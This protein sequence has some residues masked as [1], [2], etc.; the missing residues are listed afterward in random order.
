M[1]K[2]VKASD[3]DNF[4]HGKA[5]VGGTPSPVTFTKNPGMQS[6]G[7]NTDIAK[8]QPN[9]LVTNK[10]ATKKLVV[11]ETPYASENVALLQRHIVYAK[12]CLSDSLKRGEAP[13]V[14]SLLYPQVLDDRVKLDHDLAMLCSLSWIRGC[15]MVVVY[16]DYGITPGMQ[17]AI[18]TAKIKTVKIEYRSLGKVAG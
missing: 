12:L 7:A 17:V 11:V 3:L 4:F 14:S 16:I 1:A 10:V 8:M 13:L 5:T 2:T 6:S 18:N 15:D 9:E